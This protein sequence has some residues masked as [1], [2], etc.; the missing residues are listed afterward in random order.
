MTKIKP[1]FSYYG[2]KQR[3]AH[4]LIPLIPK[5]VL[6]VEPFAG[7][8]AVLFAKPLPQVTNYSHYREVLNDTNHDITNLFKVLRDDGE[9]LEAL[10]KLTPHSREEHR[11]CKAEPHTGDQL[12]D[13][14]RF[15]VRICQSFGN[16]LD[17]GW[18]KSKIVNH[19]AAWDNKCNLGQAIN[20]LRHVQINSV[21]AIQCIKEWDAPHAFFYVDPP[22]VGTHQGHY[23]GYT[24]S[25]L[26]SLCQTLDQSVGAFV[27]S[28]YDNEIC[29][30]FGWDKREF[31][32][33]CSVNSYVTNRNKART[34]CVWV[35]G[36][37]EEM[38][39]DMKKALQRPEFD[40]FNGSP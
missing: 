1:P 30:S 28:S 3:M 27:L 38:R 35:R 22:Y 13:A 8:G 15:M 23:G 17:D 11:R 20:R 7:S 21:D 6:Y 26:L 25:D 16:K 14:R 33:T 12:E 32:A 31:A 9:R 40:V 4:H 36:P 5:H 37:T 10:L 2:G 39:D 29:N 19:A 24:E 18:A 34:E